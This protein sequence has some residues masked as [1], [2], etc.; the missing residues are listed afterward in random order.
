MASEYYRGPCFTGQLFELEST[1]SVMVKNSGKVKNALI[2]KPYE[3]SKGVT[4][5]ECLLEAF[6]LS[7]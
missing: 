2:Y 4:G 1:W 5:R 3:V 7:P 6:G